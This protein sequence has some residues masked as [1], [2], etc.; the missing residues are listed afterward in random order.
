MGAYALTHRDSFE[1]KQAALWAAGGAIVGGTL[2]AGAEWVAGAIGT[3]KAAS[4]ATITILWLEQQAQRVQHIMDPKHAWDRLIQL[5]GN[6]MRDY[7]TIQPYLQEVI[8]SGQRT[9]RATTE[10]GIVWEFVKTING[11]EI[12]VT[13]IELATKAFQIADAWIKTR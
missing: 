1:W 12:V 4:T 9:Q 2:G 8:M 5:S 7:Q 11:Q 6:V 10:A 3:A 13:G